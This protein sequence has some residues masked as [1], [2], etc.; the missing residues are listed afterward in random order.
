MK[1]PQFKSLMDGFTRIESVLV[2][3]TADQPGFLKV[4]EL[5]PVYFFQNVNDFPKAT[6]KVTGG[7]GISETNLKH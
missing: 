2:L 4:V 6:R 3:T 1:L 7:K 5:F